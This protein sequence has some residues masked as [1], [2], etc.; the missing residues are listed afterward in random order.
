MEIEK[1][2]ALKKGIPL[3]LLGVFV[4]LLYI[5]FFVGF[6]DIVNTFLLADPLYYS[7][8][9]IMFL[10]NMTFYSLTWWS[11]LNILSVKT[12]FRKPFLFIWVGAFV[13]LLIPAEAVSGEVSRT[14]LMYRDSNENAGKIVASVVSHRILSMAITLGGMIGASTFFVLRYKPAELV[15]GFLLLVG[16][17]TAITLF[18]LIYLSLKE[19]ATTRVV[20]W[21][22][23][24]IKRIFKG[25][26]KET[27]VSST[28][29]RMLKEFHEGIDV[30]GENPRRLV[31]PIAFT[32]IAW[33]FDILIAFFVFSS[34][35][36]SV[37]FSAIVIVYS[38]S[39][40]VQTFP[41]GIPGEVGLVEIVM[42]SLY[43]LLLQGVP[44]ITP[45]IVAV[46]TI[47][48]RALTL[49]AKLVISGVAAQ[50]VGIKM[51][52]GSS[53]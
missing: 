37:P 30:L 14:Y 8:A 44:G 2:S 1:I 49:W 27:W 51:L 15:V 43:V 26:L 25:R 35:N 31:S 21:L 52:M 32:L 29:K 6:A 5:H 39:M 53:N 17:G 40:A 4:F 20:D 48:I 36:V 33:L 50:W 45:A 18:L 7:L 3:L 42:T 28:A 16:V 13:D 11:L 24:L 10:L 9:F 19:K 23:N 41:I 22:V 34:L 38:I 47:L 12:T 46:A